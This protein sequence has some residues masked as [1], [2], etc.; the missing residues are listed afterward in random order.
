MGELVTIEW[1]FSAALAREMTRSGKA[2]IVDLS[3]P[4]PL[5][6]EARIRSSY[7][8]SLLQAAGFADVVNVPEDTVGYRNAGLTL[9]FPEEIPNL[10]GEHVNR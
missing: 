2:L 9:Q 10:E 3:A 5:F 8:A 6:C 1:S 7:A 4:S